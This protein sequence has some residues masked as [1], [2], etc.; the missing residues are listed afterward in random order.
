MEID[1]DQAR[2]LELIERCREL[3]AAK[4]QASDELRQELIDFTR[5]R[6]DK[7]H[8]KSVKRLEKSSKIN[9]MIRLLVS[10]SLFP[11]PTSSDPDA[12]SW[13][14][15]LAER[16]ELLWYI[17]D[18]SAQRP[19]IELAALGCLELEL[20]ERWGRNAEW[21]E[22][23]HVGFDGADELTVPMFALA[24]RLE[25]ERAAEFEDRL[26]QLA[27]TKRK[28]R[29]GELIGLIDKHPESEA[30][31][32]IVD[33]TYEALFKGCDDEQKFGMAKRMFNEFRSRSS[34]TKHDK[35]RLLTDPMISQNLNNT[36][37]LDLLKDLSIHVPDQYQQLYQ[38]TY[39]T[40]ILHHPEMLEHSDVLSFVSVHGDKRH[41]PFLYPISQQQT[42]GFFT[43][44][45][46]PLARRAQQ[47]IDQ[48]VARE[49][50]HNVS[51][52]L[53]E[54]KG[55]G[56][57]LTV[58]EASSGAL[59]LSDAAQTPLAL[60]PPTPPAELAPIQPLVQQYKVPIIAG[61]SLLILALVALTLQLLVG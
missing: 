46:T 55:E 6:Y 4:Q 45:A 57:E 43:V 36:K 13:S 33:R 54:S 1:Q 29:L 30:L 5:E 41:I 61:A 49:G 20:R 25:P 17:I 37:I 7:K 22:F 40:A 15:M 32:S 52:M 11:T 10:D 23:M 8:A 47:I 31:A 16:L 59:S 28:T 3:I 48:I 53:T 38:Q 39:L 56:G 42:A 24:A 60:T 34:Y 58:I 27:F 35:W 51:G 2:K 18:D 44:E 9:R 14:P 21:R 26:E 12:P 50:L 19:V